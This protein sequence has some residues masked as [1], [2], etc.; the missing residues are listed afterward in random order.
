MHLG[1]QARKLRTTCCMSRIYPFVVLL[2]MGLLS[3]CGT[4]SNGRGWGQDATPF[5]G[6]HRIHNAAIKAAIEPSTWI[7]AAA[8]AVL[9]IGDFDENLSDWAVDHTPIFGSQD[10]AKHAS[11]YLW[12]AAGVGYLATALAAPSGEDGKQWSAAKLKGIT[13]GAAALS[14]NLGVTEILKDGA[15]RTRPDG[16]NEDGFPSHHASS[17]AV[18]ATLASRNLQ[19]LAI[20]YRAR[21]LL[22]LG[23]TTFAAGSAWARVEG[24]QHYPSD[25][26][27]GYA[28]GHFLSA[29]VNDAFLGLD[30]SDDL[31]LTVEPSRNS[32]IVGLRWVY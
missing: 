29:F 14:L 8:A 26:L 6:W 13:V 19:S 31:V 27:A 21:N 1:R 25:V 9:Q 15:H 4:L 24:K 30:N 32:V 10:R 17:A 18:F 11:E 16:S 3:G 7:P 22:Q 28:I 2:V 23:F 12:G 5:P 20:S